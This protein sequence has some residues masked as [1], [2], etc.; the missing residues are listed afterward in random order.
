MKIQIDNAELQKALDAIDKFGGKKARQKF[1]NAFNRAGF[2]TRKRMIE[3]IGR[4]FK[5]P[6]QYTRNSPYF[7][8]FD[9]KD[10]NKLGGGFLGFRKKKS[11]GVGAGIYLMP[12]EWGG[13]RA[14]KGFERRLVRM[15]IMKEGYFAVPTKAMPKE[16]RSASSLEKL[17]NDLGRVITRIDLDKKKSKAKRENYFV[18]TNKSGRLEPGIYLRTS[19][20][21]QVRL[22][23][24]VDKVTYQ[25][26]FNFYKQANKD[27]AEL[28]PSKLKDELEKG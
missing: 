16:L 5:N 13:S 7:Q 19:T 18:I 12:Q 24:F 4:I 6:N 20:S 3:Y 9:W 17:A 15:G 14:L 28:F 11:K 10:D 1:K 25:R 21:K 27:F 26:I 23:A 8:T 2:D 22:F